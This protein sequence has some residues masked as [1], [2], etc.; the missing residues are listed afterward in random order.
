MM[1]KVNECF[2][3]RSGKTR[4]WNDLFGA[5]ERQNKKVERLVSSRRAAK[6]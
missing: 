3:P 4:K 1:K 2:A 6:E 5:A